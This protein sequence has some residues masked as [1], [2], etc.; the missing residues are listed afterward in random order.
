[1][2]VWVL[3]SPLL[4][5]GVV[6]MVAFESRYSAPNRDRWSSRDAAGKRKFYQCRDVAVERD[7]IT[8]VTSLRYPKRTREAS[9]ISMELT[10]V[11]KI[12]V[13]SG[14]TKQVFMVE[15]ACVVAEIAHLRRNSRQ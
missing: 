7:A 4:A 12:A 1:K 3:R 10:I 15:Q 13:M 8:L 2:P 14:R 9:R 11:Q 6:S 5:S